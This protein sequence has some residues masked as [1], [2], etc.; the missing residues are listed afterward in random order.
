MKRENEVI[1]SDIDLGGV[2]FVD[3][4]FKNCKLIYS[5]GDPPTLTRCTYE[6][7]QFEFRR[8]AANTVAFLKSM[9][10]PESGL[11]QVVRETFPEI[12]Q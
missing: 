2:S 9:A 6:N 10:N 5:G 1:T 11:Q 12:A 8:R 7:I 3:C 4:E